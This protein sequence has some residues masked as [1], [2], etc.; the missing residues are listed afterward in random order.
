MVSVG[1]RP[2]LLLL[3]LLHELSVFNVMLHRSVFMFYVIFNIVVL[4]SYSVS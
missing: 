3:V 2:T 1:L 4:L